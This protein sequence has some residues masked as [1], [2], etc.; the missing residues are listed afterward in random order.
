MLQPQE[1]E[2]H[3]PILAW[4]PARPRLPYNRVT[5][6]YCPR[7]SWDTESTGSGSPRL[8]LSGA[9][10]TTPPRGPSRDAR[11]NRN[12][13][14]IV[15]Y[16][17]SARAQQGDRPGM[18]FSRPSFGLTKSVGQRLELIFA[19]KTGGTLPA[20]HDL[21]EEVSEEAFNA[22]VEDL[23]AKVAKGGG[24][25]TFTDSWATTGSRTWIDL[26]NVV[27]FTARPA[28]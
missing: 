2:E 4:A 12:H 14:G 20:V 21:G 5:T 10:P 17:Q 26:S 23:Q 16:S 15:S 27:G 24:V 9:D 7:T 25:A 22:F 28:H 1:G 3:G 11:G 13:G 18:G 8:E 6:R 19:L